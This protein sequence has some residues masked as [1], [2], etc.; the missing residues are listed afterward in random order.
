MPEL[1]WHYGYYG[2]LGL[3]AV[4]ALSLILYFKRKRLF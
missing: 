1:R 4:I 2:V 3:L